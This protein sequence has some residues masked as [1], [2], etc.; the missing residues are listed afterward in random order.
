MISGPAATNALHWEACS[1]K[2]WERI[3]KTSASD[4][5]PPRLF[6]PSVRLRASLRLG[7]CRPVTSAA[8]AA[9]AKPA[10]VHS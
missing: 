7:I 1:E 5:P 4:S 9:P 6:P 2:R 3:L 10:S 8:E